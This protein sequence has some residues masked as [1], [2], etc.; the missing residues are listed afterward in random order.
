MVCWEK[1][2]AHL[3]LVVDNLVMGI[4]CGASERFGDGV[5]EVNVV[6]GVP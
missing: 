1:S 6:A 3:G 4:G 2:G 5:G